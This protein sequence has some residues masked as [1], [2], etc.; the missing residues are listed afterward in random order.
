[1][2][3]K[4]LIP[5]G[6]SQTCSI[7]DSGTISIPQFVTQQLGWTVPS[8]IAVSYIDEPLTLLL[9]QAESDQEGYTLAYQTRPAT[10]KT[11]TKIT[12]SA[13][14][15]GV[16]RRR[17]ELP[18]RGLTPIF[19]SGG[20]Y[21]LA[22]VVQG[23]QWTNEDFSQSGLK[24]I[25]GSFKGVYQ[26]LS[27]SGTVLRI[28]EG[29]ISARMSERL[30]EDRLTADARTLQYFRLIDKEETQ[31]WERILIAQYEQQ[32]GQLPPLNRIRS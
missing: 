12:C 9:S 23:P 26:L 21:P 15:S 14:A 27:A 7:S 17:V 3:V 1:M 24:R 13:F 6:N 11:G 4:K 32:N 19:L 29:S 31:L 16:L 30:K 28:G 5:S 20:L 22:L 18:L 10:S 8:K 2:P 25:S